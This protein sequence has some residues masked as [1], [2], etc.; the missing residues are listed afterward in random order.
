[1]SVSTK[2][3]CRKNAPCFQ[4]CPSGAGSVDSCTGVRQGDREIRGLAT[5]ADGADT[6]SKDLVRDNHEE[7]AWPARP[8]L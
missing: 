7:G 6:V 5:Q 3:S 2:L 8:N 4:R 1:M